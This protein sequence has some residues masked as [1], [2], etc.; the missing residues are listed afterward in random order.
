MSVLVGGGDGECC[1]GKRDDTIP[2]LEV[3]DRGG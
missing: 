2:A 1:V 3:A